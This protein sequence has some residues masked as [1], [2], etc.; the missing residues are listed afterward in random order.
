MCQHVIVIHWCES[1]DVESG[2][3]LD[4][5]VCGSLMIEKYLITEKLWLNHELL[6][7]ITIKNM[8]NRN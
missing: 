2:Q 5:R 1:T 3:V 6:S 8:I 7:L 4:L